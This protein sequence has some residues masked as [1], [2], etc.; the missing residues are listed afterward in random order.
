[1]GE[2]RDSEGVEEPEGCCF[3]I[4]HDKWLMAGCKI[5]VLK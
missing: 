5:V 1:M 4:G 3:E 2:G